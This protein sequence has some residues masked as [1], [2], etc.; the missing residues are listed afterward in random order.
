M[1]TR[2]TWTGVIRALG[3]AVFG[4]LRA[5]FGLLVLDLK[6]SG[7]KAG[8]GLALVVVAVGLL[9]WVLPI[10]LFAAIWGLHAWLEVSLGL[11]AL[12]VGLIGLGV[13]LVLSAIAYF[14]FLRKVENPA[15]AFRQRLASHLDWWQQQ[16]EPAQLADGDDDE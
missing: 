9:F 2:K 1:G 15:S 7:K 13:A 11:A 16:F 5:E 10:L 12:W 4:V 6:R 8:V 3:D 14:G